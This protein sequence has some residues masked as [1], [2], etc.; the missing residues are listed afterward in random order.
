[1]KIELTLPELKAV[2][3]E[4]IR[5]ESR[6]WHRLL[7]RLET[8][9]NSDELKQTISEYREDAPKNS[10]LDILKVISPENEP[11]SRITKDTLDSEHR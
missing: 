10:W 8:V 1:M 9:E 7:K 4:T 6:Y 11:L 5:L 3:A 2:V